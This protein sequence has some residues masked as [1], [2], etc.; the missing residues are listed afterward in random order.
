[1]AIGA[2]F[3]ALNT[4]YASVSARAREIATLRAIGFGPAAVAIATLFE[5][6]MLAL[7]GGLLGGAIVYLALN[8][9]T[10]STL[11]QTFS[12]VVF[13]FAVTGTLL[14]QGIVAALIIGAIGGLFPAIRAARIPV[15]DALREL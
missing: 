5:A 11:N 15:V 10:A 7:I 12:Q 9:I 14:A 4:M 1:M 2:V 6:T 13:N 3:G 8:G